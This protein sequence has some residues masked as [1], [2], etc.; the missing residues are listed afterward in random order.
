MKIKFIL[1]FT[2][3]SFVAFGQTK[4]EKRIAVEPGSALTLN[5]DY[6]ELVKLQTWDKNEILITGTV[7]I[8]E[9]E[10]D[11]AFELEIK[12]EGKTIGVTSMIKD[13]EN[14]PKRITIK[15]GD[16]E[17]V[18]RAK[19]INDP[20]VQ[21]FFAQHGRDYSYISNGLLHHILLTVFVPEQI[22]TDVELKFGT[23]EVGKFNAPLSVVSKHGS[24]DASI[25]GTTTGVIIA[26]TEFGE[27]LSNLDVKFSPDGAGKAGGRWTSVTAKPGVGPTYRFESRFGN[28]YLR[29]Q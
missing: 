17:F 11:S 9:G 16:T 18:F 22:R 7:S 19:D 2:V 25:A 10:N 27:I 21:K 29:K 26:R 1:G 13:R 20:E 24:V 15:K 23:V 14:L 8:N 4:V 3:Y 6:P 5:F 12:Q 28:V